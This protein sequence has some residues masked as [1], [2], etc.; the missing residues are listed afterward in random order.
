MTIASPILASNGFQYA[1]E[2]S[3][4]A[5]VLVC[6]ALG[7]LSVIAWTVM[8]TKFITLRR[9]EEENQKFL[10]TFRTAGSPLEP[11]E[12]QVQP[13]G[14]P[15]FSVYA[16]GCR[17][18]CIHLLGSAERDEL[19]GARVR[20]AER[21]TPSQ[22]EGIRTA[23]D[24]AVGEM[25]LRLESRMNFLATAVSG[26]PFL[27]LL[28][29][30]WG[31]MDTFSGI[32]D[33]GGGASLAEMAPGVSAALVTTVIGLLVAIP[34]MFGYNYLINHIKSMVMSLDHYAAELQTR[35]ERRYVDYGRKLDSEIAAIA[36]DPTDV[37][38]AQVAARRTKS[39][40]TAAPPHQPS[41][42]AS[43][44]PSTEPEEPEDDFLNLG[45]GDD[46]PDARHSG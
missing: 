40:K 13:K 37:P 2:Q 25:A 10:E 33:A 15:L 28:G 7:V 9:A 16:A 32:A 19:F 21:I 17:E 39:R 38:V 20:S 8:I 12:K 22:M 35:F 41:S 31:V 5:G 36:P 34:A 14:A 43:E 26:A 4:V 18:L 42:S 46:D 6:V 23:M 3:S 1:I 24:R 45:V 44:T 11:F 30:V 29:T 27:G